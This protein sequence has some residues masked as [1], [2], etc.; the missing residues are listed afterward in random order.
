[1]DL[2]G[3]DKELMAALFKTYNHL[4][5]RIKESDELVKRFYKEMREAQLIDSVPGF[6][7]F[8]LNQ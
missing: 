4:E 5:E 7:T 8:I 2:P 1:L 6:A 3:R